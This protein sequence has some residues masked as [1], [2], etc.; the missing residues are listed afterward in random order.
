M[1]LKTLGQYTVKECKVKWSVNEHPVSALSLERFR[2]ILV[3]D[4]FAESWQCFAL[5]F[6]ALFSS[7]EFGA[8]DFGSQFEDDWCRSDVVLR[9]RAVLEGAMKEFEWHQSQLLDRVL[10][11]VSVHGRAGAWFPFHKAHDLE[12][13]DSLMVCQ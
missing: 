4:W 9:R 1:I 5:A 3:V 2:W 12:W 8:N 13:V 11:V 6:G 10:N 7:V